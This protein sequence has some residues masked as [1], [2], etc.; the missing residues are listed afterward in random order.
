M[1]KLALIGGIRSLPIRGAVGV[2][3]L[4]NRPMVAK[5]GERIVW[6]WAHKGRRICDPWWENEGPWHRDWKKHF[7]ES[8]HEIVGRDSNGEAHIADI[9]LPN[10]LVIELQHSAMSLDEM[11]SREAFYGNMVWIV[12]TE[13]FKKNITIFDPLPD[14]EYS[15][16]DDLVFVR[17]QPAWRDWACPR[18]DNFDGLMFYRRSESSPDSNMVEMYS[19]RE[20][21][22]YFPGSYS[23]HRLFLW[24]KPR[25]IWFL[26]SKPTYLDFGRG[27]LGR[28]MRYRG[29]PDSMMCLKFVSKSGLIEAFANA[30]HP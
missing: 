5:C 21:A 12:D 4:C 2:C 23:G 16:V 26:T 18:R 22:E 20:L 14:P 13:P 8:C 3:Q 28:L 7:P 29:L 19:G 24:M 25:E 9:K 1:L 15:F 17:P 27:I 10:G 30:S 6:H 11:R